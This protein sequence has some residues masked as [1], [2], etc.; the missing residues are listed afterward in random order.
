MRPRRRDTVVGWIALTIVLAMAVSLALN[1]LFIE[2]GGV[3]AR[4]ALDRTNL[5][6][7][8][9]ALTRVMDAAPP[10]LRRQ[11]AAAAASR[12]PDYIVRWR[13]DQSRFQLPAGI[14]LSL[15]DGAGALLKQY[16]NRPDARIL[17]VQPDEWPE[18]DGRRGYLLAIQL[19]DE[20]WVA[21]S[22]PYRSW[23]LD[24]LPRTLISLAL[25]LISTLL[26]AWVATRRLARPLQAFTRAARRFGGDIQAPPI[27]P[28]GPYELREATQAFNAM[29]AR[30][31]RLV[32]ART[33]MLAAI[34]H[35]L[36]APL[37]RMRLR[38]EFVRDRK[39]QSRM[40][41]DIDE[42]QAMINAALAFFR[43]DTLKESP[44]YFDLGELLLTLVEDYGDQGLPV[45]YENNGH[46]VHFGR[47]AALKRALTNLI[48][49][50]LKYAGAATL[51]LR[52]AD[53]E[54]IIQ[55]C[56][57]GPGLAEA[58]LERVME[59]FYRLEASRNR[60]TG[61]VGLGLATARAVANEEGG[62]LTL[63]NRPGGGLCATLTLPDA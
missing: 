22:A 49:N 34:S 62:G 38:A 11:L 24:P 9:A 36:R 48:D 60:A 1:L 3:W 39:Q 61:G 57:R 30:I 40:F 63:S 8:V 37:T 26:V 42:M 31:Q 54:V 2:L 56:D 47:P 32:L 52:R 59:P 53:N 25:V 29:Q 35:D 5:L 51:E 6:R 33:Q 41:R 17:I 19:S 55:V 50:A 14:D 27:A 16:L 12:D 21:F 23:G 10:S 44:T 4:P 28:Q 18:G 58:Q 45:N 15:D 20:S 7:E 13:L 43:D 46:H